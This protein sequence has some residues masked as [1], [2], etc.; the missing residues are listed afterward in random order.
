MLEKLEVHGSHKDD[1]GRV[2]SRKIDLPPVFDG[3]RA[4]YETWRTQ[5]NIWKVANADVAVARL[6]PVLLQ[7]LPQGAGGLAFVGQALDPGWGWGRL[8]A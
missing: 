5:V 4:G 2:S 7:A 6:G 8:I 1:A 3:D